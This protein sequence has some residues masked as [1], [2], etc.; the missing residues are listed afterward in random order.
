MT[1]TG[2]I[3]KITGT[4]GM[5]YIGSTINFEKR[6]NLHK[7]ENNDTSCSLLTKPIHFEIIDSREYKLVKTLRLMEQ[8]YLDNT[9]NINKQRAYSNLFIKRKQKKQYHI[10][11]RKRI[12]ETKRKYR[13]NNKEKLDKQ[14]QEY[15]IKNREKILKQKKEYFIKNRENISKLKKEKVKCECGCILRK[16]DLARHKRSPKHINLLNQKSIN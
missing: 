16:S 3:Y 5:V 2:Y 1:F 11:N 15:R 10:K 14:N 7:R 6:M 9:I 4:C 8:F 13:K 12:R